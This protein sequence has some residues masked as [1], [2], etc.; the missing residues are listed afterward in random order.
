MTIVPTK[1]GWW[2]GWSNL[3]THNK[4]SHSERH[5]DDPIMSLVPTKGE[6]WGVQ[7]HPLATISVLA[8][9][10]K[11]ITSSHIHSQQSQLQRAA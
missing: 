10:M 8:S 5:E 3:P 7:T 2:G 9:V 1:G 6:W 11:I 4:L